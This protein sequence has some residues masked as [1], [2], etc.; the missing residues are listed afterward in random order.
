MIPF[1]FILAQRALELEKKLKAANAEGKCC[2]QV[3]HF[4]GFYYP[5]Y[6]CISH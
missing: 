1:P 3:I 4:Q 5:T 6:Y 2:K